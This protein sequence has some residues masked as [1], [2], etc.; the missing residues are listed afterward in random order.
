MTLASVTE[1]IRIVS[2]L[3]LQESTPKMYE[4][5][6]EGR[7]LLFWLCSEEDS[8]NKVQSLADW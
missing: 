4:Q 3:E 1:S 7:L 5:V 6:A 8:S 2:L